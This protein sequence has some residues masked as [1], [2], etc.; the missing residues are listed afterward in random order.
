MNADAAAARMGATVQ[1]LQGALGRLCDEEVTDGLWP[2]RLQALQQ[3]L[4]AVAAGAPDELLLVLIAGAA[5]LQPRYG[6]HHALA[7]A[8][9]VGLAAAVL[10]W[11][12][13][14]QRTVM[15]AALTM[16]LS[17]TALQDDLAHRER[18]LTVEQRLA[19]E[20]HPARSVERLRALGVDDALWLDT[21]G[22][23]HRE[24]DELLAA[25]PPAARL[26]ALL[27]R[28]DVFVAKVSPRAGRP[29][30]PTTQAARDACLGP[31]GRPD[32]LGAAILRSLGLY[33][34]GSLVTL[35]N[36]ETAV[37]WQRGARLD[38]PLVLSIAGT[39]RQPLPQPLLRRTADAAY[40]IK[41]PAGRAEARIPWDPQ[42]LLDAARPL[43]A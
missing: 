22:L 39:S 20:S 37:V 18:T 13:E 28:V 27:R 2:D 5:R 14:E 32:T 31:D 8:P 43:S 33:P 40:A 4:A 36:G 41:G 11:T 6:V 1:E 24:P 17:I 30:L 38:Q 3:R 9:I 34:P 42:A 7:C 12:E 10:G 19:V 26:A 35:V 16:N 21:V 29:G 23:H 15:L 25:L